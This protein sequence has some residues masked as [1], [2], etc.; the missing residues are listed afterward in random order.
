[1]VILLLWWCIRTILSDA[2][3]ACHRYKPLCKI[4]AND[5]LSLPKKQGVPRHQK[6]N[7]WG[8]PMA[9]LGCYF[10]LLVDSA[11]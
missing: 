3:A 8:T 2:S 1:M 9:S 5:S 6:C 7:A 10:H 11:A 4:S